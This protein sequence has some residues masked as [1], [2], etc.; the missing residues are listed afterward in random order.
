[1]SNPVVETLHLHS[2]YQG[3]GLPVA[4]L[5]CFILVFSVAYKCEY[6]KGSNSWFP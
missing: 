5:S 2:T 4:L 6:R 1:M 3:P